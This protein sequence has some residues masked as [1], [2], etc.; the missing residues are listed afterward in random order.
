MTGKDDSPQKKEMEQW[1]Q[2]KKTNYGHLLLFLSSTPLFLL[3]NDLLLGNVVPL[4]A[5]LVLFVLEGD[6]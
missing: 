5:L 3:L 4:A 1:N 2:D 6:L